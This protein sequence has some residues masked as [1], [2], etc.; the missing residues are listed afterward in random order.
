MRVRHRPVV[1]PWRPGGRTQ[2]L[3]DEDPHR[4]GAASFMA[5]G[6][7]LPN[8]L[9][10]VLTLALADLLQGVPEFWLKAHAGPAAP[11]HDVAVD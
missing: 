9:A 4:A 11:G 2:V 3:D 10:D 1:T 5:G 7:D 8:E 6:L